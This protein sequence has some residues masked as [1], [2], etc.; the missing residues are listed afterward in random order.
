VTARFGLKAAGNIFIDG[1]YCAN[2][3]K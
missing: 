1:F 2:V 3:I